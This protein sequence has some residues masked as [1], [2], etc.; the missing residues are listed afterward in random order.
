MCERGRGKASARKDKHKT[1]RIPGSLG[2]ILFAP[3]SGDSDFCFAPFI[4]KKPV[5]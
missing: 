2:T 1:R 4:I 5:E 3:G